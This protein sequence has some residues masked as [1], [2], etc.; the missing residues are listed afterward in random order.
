M[1]DRTVFFTP[2]RAAR[3]LTTWALDLWPYVNGKAL[4]LGLRL[5]EMELSNMLDVVHFMFEEDSRYSSSEEAESVSAMRAALYA[6]MYLTTYRYAVHGPSRSNSA[7]SFEYS[8]NEIK[9]YIPPTEFDPDARSP[10]GTVLDAP[11]G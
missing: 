11:I 3:G 7:N 10:F 5:A 9:P 1:V 2:G 8:S 4:T 6:Q